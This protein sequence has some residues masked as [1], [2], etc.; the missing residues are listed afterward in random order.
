M[1]YTLEDCDKTEIT[2]HPLKT[3]THN[4][5]QE[6]IQQYI[7]YTANEGKLPRMDT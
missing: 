3:I 6:T 1:N 2:Q 7:K 4:P 5:N